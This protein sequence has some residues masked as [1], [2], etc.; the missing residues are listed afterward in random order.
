MQERWFVTLG[1][2]PMLVGIAALVLLRRPEAATAKLPTQPGSPVAALAPALLPV[3]GESHLGVIIAG[4]TADL[5]A[6]IG[7]S[8]VRVFVREGARVHEGDPL[9][10]IDP[11]TASS[12]ARMAEAELAQQMSAV[13]RAQADYD[14]AS[15][16]LV[17]LVA[18][19]SGIPAQTIVAARSREASA[20]AAMAE[21]RA[22]IDVGKARI[23][24]EEARIRKHMIA[25]PFT[26]VVVMLGVD[27]GDVVSAGQ[28]VARVISEDHD[29]RFAVP[30]AARAFTTQGA[31]IS[32]RV[33]GT[34]VL[35]QGLVTD[36]MP[37]VDA[38]SGMVFV[39]ARLDLDAARD[40]A[41]VAGT[42][43]QVTLG[44]A[45]PKQPQG[46]VP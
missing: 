3:A 44:V 17:R 12:E 7:G 19:G 9:V 34:Q 16:L 27:P 10:Y 11:A 26:G 8:V 39:R 46:A 24:R 32:I 6:E 31:R 2:V 30:A 15:D 5:G 37:E 38:A 42:S 28:V 18:A 14:E 1:F 13:A 33:P 40:S 22:G 45:V 20:R 21:A 35:A 43:V 25:A 4:H 29:V 36:V 41:I 23:N